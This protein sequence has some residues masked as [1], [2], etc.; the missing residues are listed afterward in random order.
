MVRIRQQASSQSCFWWQIEPLHARNSENIEAPVWPWH[1]SSITTRDV[2]GAQWIVVL[3]VF[4][5]QEKHR[6]ECDGYW[7]AV[8]KLRSKERHPYSSS[9]NLQGIGNRWP[10]FSPAAG[11]RWRE[12]LLSTMLAW[13]HRAMQNTIIRRIELRG[14]RPLGDWSWLHCQKSPRGMV[15]HTDI[16]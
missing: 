7:V 8:V 6:G 13:K 3:C 5:Q 14:C 4:D 12:R 1:C 10:E 15:L 16:A 9:A 2:S 11:G